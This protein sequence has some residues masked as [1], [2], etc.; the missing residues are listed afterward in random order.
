[1][2]VTPLGVPYRF[3][4]SRRGKLRQ[5]RFELL[6]GF[7]PKTPSPCPGWS[8]LRFRMLTPVEVRFT[9]SLA[10]LLLA[11]SALGV[12][13]NRSFR[14]TAFILCQNVFDLF[15]KQFKK[16]PTA[17]NEDSVSAHICNVSSDSFSSIN[18]VAKF[19]MTESFQKVN[20]FCEFLRIYGNFV[21][22]KQ[23]ERRIS[24]LLLVISPCVF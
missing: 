1:M 19:I 8:G 22:F 14:A 20:E 3:P 6:R 17:E 21:N 4:D 13:V 11:A 5:W 10:W 18:V 24:P 12:P 23:K 7:L 15:E 2:T 16:C 9:Q